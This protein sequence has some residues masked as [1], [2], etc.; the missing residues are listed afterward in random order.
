VETICPTAS[1]IKNNIIGVPKKF[2]ADNASVLGGTFDVVFNGKK[3]TRRSVD[4]ENRLGGLPLRGGIV[5]GD[6]LRLVV[7]GGA[8]VITSEKRAAAE[9]GP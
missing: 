8:L 1:Q 7:E 4:R 3:L 5:A 6:S 9:A 2:I